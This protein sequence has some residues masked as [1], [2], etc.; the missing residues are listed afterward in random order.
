[1]SLKEIQK[2]VDDWVG[3]YKEGYWPV[4]AQ[5]A[6]LIEE[7]GELA[8]EINLKYGPKN[9]KESEKPVEMAGEMADIIFTIAAMANATGLDLDEAWQK[10][11]TKYYTRDD[12][13]WEKK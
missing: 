2:N 4:H 7:V 13:R 1:M 12:K 11:M 3:Q 9:K 10:V 8:R 5:L 6:R